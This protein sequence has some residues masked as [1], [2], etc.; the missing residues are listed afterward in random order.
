MSIDFDELPSI[1]DHDGVQGARETLKQARERLDTLK[2]ERQEAQAKVEA[3]ED[4]VDET[5]I[6][7]TTGDATSEDLENA[8]YELEVAQD[9]AEDLEA[10]V[11]AQ[12]RAIE[13]LQSRLENAKEEAAGEVAS[14]Y[15]DE[16][17]D[18]LASQR[19]AL[20]QLATTLEDAHALKEELTRQGLRRDER[21]PSLEE[22]LRIPGGTSVAPDR[23]RHLANRR[24]EQLD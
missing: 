7:R 2:E 13:R 11:Q 10:E 8:K 3:L 21:V 20:R 16:A 18:V 14:A 1:D 19:R 23:L 24:D 15:S 22:K 4:E 6:Q 5:R 12:K 9:E 17:E